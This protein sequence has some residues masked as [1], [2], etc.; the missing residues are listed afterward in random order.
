MVAMIKDLIEKIFYILLSGIFLSLLAVACFKFERW[1][2]YE[3]E[4]KD[5]MVKTIENKVKKECL[6]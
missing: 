6:K 5:R 4:Y 1:F 2:N 3:F